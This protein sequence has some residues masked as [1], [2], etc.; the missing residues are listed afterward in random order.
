[1]HMKNTKILL[2]LIALT[3]LLTA[4]GKR[5]VPPMER[6][7]GTLAVAGFTHPKYN[8]QLLAGYVPLEGRE[9]DR[10]VLMQLDQTLE[11]TLN[12]H[13]VLEYVPPANTR[14]CQEIITFRNEGQRISALQYWT[15]VGRCAKVDWLFVP[16]VLSWRDREGKEWGATE[17]AAVS[18]DFYYIDVAAGE[19]KVR[20]HFEETQ[21]PLSE[22][23][24]NAGSYFERGGG[25]VP[26]L[27]LAQEGIEIKLTEMGL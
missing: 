27:R 17:A 2:I 7:E 16:Q 9:M 26:A 11:S 5:V 20:R 4:C 3:L 8:W 13:K 10:E 6:P 24:G 23:L 1:M 15:E 18:L 25:W 12:A 19:L 21:L 22:D 14:K